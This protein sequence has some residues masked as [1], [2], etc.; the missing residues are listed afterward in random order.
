MT[1]EFK[2][3]NNDVKT[4]IGTLDKDKPYT[5]YF[6]NSF[7]VKATVEKKEYYE[8]M[9]KIESKFKFFIKKL[10]LNEP[11][12][13]SQF[14][15]DFDNK[16]K[17]LKYNKRSFINY[18]LIVKQNSFNDIKLIKD[19]L[20]EINNKFINELFDILKENDFIQCK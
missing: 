13:E 14:I 7:W 19:K 18:E 16:T 8:D 10:I 2:F 5:I 17:Y 3:K 12:F 9:A 11:L 6:N 4:K 20:I 15:F 1:K